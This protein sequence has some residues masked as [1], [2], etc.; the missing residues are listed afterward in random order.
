MKYAR[1]GRWSN[2][3][4]GFLEENRPEELEQMKKDGTLTEYKNRIDDEYNERFHRM[5]RAELERTKLE[6]RRSRH[7]IGLLESIGEHNQIR[8]SIAELLTAELSV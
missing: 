1:T 8:A 4:I 2:I 6:L 5:E 3:R 7:E